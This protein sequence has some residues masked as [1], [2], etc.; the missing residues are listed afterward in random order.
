MRR[1][2]GSGQA[3]V[4]LLSLG[5]IMS[6]GRAAA[7]SGGRAGRLRTDPGM[8]RRH[9]AGAFWGGH[10]TGSSIETTFETAALWPL[11]S[12]NLSAH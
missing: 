11:E 2:D 6:S 8:A 4:G 5:H 9:T 3:R 12:S 7:A 10:H 1:R